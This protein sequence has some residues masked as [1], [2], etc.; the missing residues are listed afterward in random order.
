MDLNE[1]NGERQFIMENA[2][3]PTIVLMRKY[4]EYKVKNCNAPA[5]SKSFYC[6]DEHERGRCDT[7]CSWCASKESKMKG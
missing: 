6:L 1:Y 4:A 7:Q 2:G 3:L 5:V